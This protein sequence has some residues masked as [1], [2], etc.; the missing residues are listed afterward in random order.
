[1]EA[2]ASE[3]EL[4][5]E[6]EDMPVVDLEFGVAEELPGEVAGCRGDCGFNHVVESGDLRGGWEP[7]RHPVSCCRSSG[8]FG[9]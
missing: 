6:I 7:L 1:M 2:A 3:A 4:P 9:R 8:E 5:L